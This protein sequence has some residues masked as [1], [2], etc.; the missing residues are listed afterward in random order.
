[1]ATQSGVVFWPVDPARITEE[2]GTR[3]GTHYGMDFGVAV[4]TPVLAPFDGVIVANFNDGASG[5]LTLPG[6]QKVK[7]NGPALITDLR[8]DDGLI[9]RLAH[10]SAFGA[11]PGQRVSA[12]DEIAY[13][14]NTGFSLGPHVHW[15]LR[16]D[17]RLGPGSWVNPRLFDPQPYTAAPPVPDPIL[18]E[19][20]MATYFKA[21]VNSS[22]TEK[23]NP[24]SSR[25]WAGEGREI[26]AG[27]KTFYSGV[28]ERSEDGSIR[29]LFVA[30]WDA[31]QAAYKAAGRPIPLATG[32]HGNA[33][34]EMYLT[35]RAAP[36]AVK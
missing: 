29:R 22:E 28:W 1:M 36:K 30:E 12:G 23:G 34:E 24:G 18:E 8:R 20:I 3:G 17:R 5:T 7:A 4:G 14:G 6:G 21:Q 35:T 9:S 10:L 16:W 11:E 25:I 26:P 13:S 32:V 27:S 19:D 31:I 2:A 15:E 33:I